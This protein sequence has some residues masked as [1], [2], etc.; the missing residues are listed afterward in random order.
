MQSCLKLL[1]ERPAKQL[2][3]KDIVE[4]C[5][6]NRNSFY[7][8]FADIPT[9]IEEMITEEAER[10]IEQHPTID[11]IEDC[12]QIA[13]EFALA[14]KKAA[15]H[16]YNSANRDFFEQHLWTICETVVNMY[17]DTAFADYPI[18]PDD[19]HVIVSY[20]RCQ[21]FGQIL[22]WMRS[23]MNYDILSFFHRIVE[24]RTAMNLQLTKKH[25]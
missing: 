16:L 14:N 8:H 21:C 7:Y 12:L 2:T 4:D 23:G 9:L 24:L 13:V 22:D 19:R 5:G 20:Y 18:D 15:L 11:S 3:V 17:L 10:I 1:N 25:D 6:I